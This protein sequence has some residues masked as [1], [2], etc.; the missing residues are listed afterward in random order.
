MSRLSNSWVQLCD[1]SWR[2]EFTEEAAERKDA[3]LGDLKT[4]SNLSRSDHAEAERLLA[5]IELTYKS[6]PS[7]IPRR[8]GPCAQA[9]QNQPAK[10]SYS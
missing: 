3:L 10:I 4:A 2:E 8:S 5:A 6:P 7:K 1:L 9:V